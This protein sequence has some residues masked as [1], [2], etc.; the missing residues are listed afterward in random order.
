MRIVM[1][2]RPDA[3]VHFGGDLVHAEEL[4]RALRE[5]GH[6]VQI[7]SGPSSSEEY[8]RFDIAHFFNLHTPEFTEGEMRKA[9]AAGVALALSPIFW[10]ARAEWLVARSPLWSRLARA[11]GRPT[12][13][14]LA[15][16][17]IERATRVWR[18]L[19]ESIL[20]L[21]D[22]VMPSGSSEIGP[23]RGLRRELP[24]VRVVPV[25][26]RPEAFDPSV[27]R[28]YPTELAERGVEEYVLVAARVD[29]HKNQAALC[30][31]L[32]GRGLR[33]VLAGERVDEAVARECEAEGAILL[34]RVPR[35]ALLSLYAHARV[36]ALPSFYDVPGLASLEAAAMGCGIVSTAFG[37]ARDYFGDAAFYCDPG[38]DRSIRES[39][40]DAWESG[41]KPGLSE[42]VR[43]RF[44]WEEAARLTVE[45][46]EMARDAKSA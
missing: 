21:A 35:E 43:A 45:A 7:L 46:Y 33:V 32:R 2:T 40:L 41:R 34:G 4:A 31:A 38:E 9:R 8:G 3:A 14:R 1:A 24:P 23:L 11:V 6:E 44:T 37:T 22:V 17:R 39:V 36:H 29:R 18:T 10:D 19:N 12:A 42:S 30:R 15:R 13:V 27:P 28:P 5:R 26:I 16:I 20:S 25:G